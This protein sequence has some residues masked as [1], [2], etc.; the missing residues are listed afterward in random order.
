[1]DSF[2]ITSLHITSLPH[3]LSVAL[4]A[5]FYVIHILKIS[6]STIRV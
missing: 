1:M 5:E 2:D 4:N 6:T 3:Y